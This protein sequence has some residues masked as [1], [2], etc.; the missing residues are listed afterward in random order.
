MLLVEQVDRLGRLN[1]TDWERLQ[2]LIKS[3]GVRA[4]SHQLQHTG[5]ELINRMLG[6]IN[7]M[8][9]CMTDRSWQRSQTTSVK[10]Y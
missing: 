2:G 5:D 9:C 8:S 1:S 4:T 6:A 3:K 7:G 10:R